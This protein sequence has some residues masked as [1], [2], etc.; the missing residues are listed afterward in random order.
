MA[1]LSELTT[2]Q[3]AF[4]DSQVIPP[5]YLR[6]TLH[7]DDGNIVLE[8][9]IIDA[10]EIKMNKR[11]DLDENIEQFTTG[12]LKVDLVNYQQGYDATVPG[13]T[14]DAFVTPTLNDIELGGV[15]VKISKFSTVPLGLSSW[16]EL[17]GKVF[18]VSDG[19]V[20]WSDQVL[21]VTTVDSGT[22]YQI[23]FTNS[24]PYS[25]KLQAGA[26]LEINQIIGRRATLEYI[27]GSSGEKLTAG[28]YVVSKIPDL[29]IGQATLELQD[30]FSEL[31]GENLPANNAAVKEYQRTASSTGTVDINSTNVKWSKA[32]IGEW[33][34]EITGADVSVRLF[35][36]TYPDGTTKTGRTDQNF[37]SDPQGYQNFSSLVIL[38][39]DWSGILDIGDKVII[40]TYYSQPDSHTHLS[41]GLNHVLS[42]CL[43][44]NFYDSSAGN[45][46]LSEYQPRMPLYPPSGTI[47][48][49]ITC[50]QAAALFCQHLNLSM[51]VGIDGFLNFYMF[52]PEYAASLPQISGDSDMI[53]V[54]VEFREPVKAVQVL[55]NYDW[56]A[57]EFQN[58]YV[59]PENSHESPVV[60]KLPFFSGEANAKAQASRYFSMW[61]KGLRLIRFKEKFN[62]GIAFDLA[63]RMEL[64]SD[65]P[66]ITA[67][68]VLFFDLSKNL[69]KA[70]VTVKSI[71]VSRLWENVAFYDVS[72]Y[73]TGK[74][75]F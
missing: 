67:S 2:A 56:D 17:V 35:T 42:L 15:S 22:R 73:E 32:V 7:G 29:S 19:K 34:V 41:E 57:R 53:E 59:Y 30:A 12:Q 31:L 61:N 65:N 51:Y 38:S 52:Q 66:P 75:Y 69:S 28:K 33:E 48:R 25:Y 46:L 27:L 63:E 23:N 62:Y 36:V 26:I 44:S 39:S 6:L 13:N 18:A 16:S 24:F 3:Q 37:Y 11:I 14:F 8:D 9:D 47:K 4:L 49:Q 1:H 70:E 54:E 10:E 68:Q 64:T 74:V 21:S 20:S 71:D 40:Q 43:D 72:S 55:Y 5:I 58:S 60:L 50:M 45:R